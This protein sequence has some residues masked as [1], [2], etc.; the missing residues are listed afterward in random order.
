MI[1]LLQFLAEVKAVSEGIK[2][3]MGLER[4]FEPIN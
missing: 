3:L 2:M 4:D 1:F